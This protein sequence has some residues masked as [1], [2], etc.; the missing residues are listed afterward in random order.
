MRLRYATLL[1]ALAVFAGCDLAQPDETDETETTIFGFWENLSGRLEEY[2]LVSATEVTL[3]SQDY[4]D[5]DC[6]NRSVS[7]VSSATDTRV[8]AVSPP[9]GARR[10]LVLDSTDTDRMTSTISGVPFQYERAG[11]GGRSQREVEG[12]ICGG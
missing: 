8:E 12:A 7:P 9:Y 10:V 1:V 2:E 3:Y 11:R 4:S 6:F 5:R